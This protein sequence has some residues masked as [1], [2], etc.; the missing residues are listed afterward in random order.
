MSVTLARTMQPAK[1]VLPTKDIAVC[2]LQDSRVM[3]VKMV[4]EHAFSDGAGFCY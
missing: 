3:N 2:A 4:R 1:Q